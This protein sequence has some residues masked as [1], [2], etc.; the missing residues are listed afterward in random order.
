M[1]RNT[2][3]P[4]IRVAIFSLVASAAES[5][6]CTLPSLITVIRSEM[7]N[8]SWSL[9][10]MKITVFPCSFR[11][12]ITLNKSSVSWGVSTAVGSSK[13]KTSAPGTEP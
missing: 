2:S 1:F 9:W 13:I 12:R 10:E 8:T 7:A 4:T 11:E 3:R 6:P 5:V